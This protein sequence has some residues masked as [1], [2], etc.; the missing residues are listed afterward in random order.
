MSSRAD[1]TYEEVRRILELIDQSE[2]V[3][4]RVEFDGL[5]LHVRK[6]CLGE[7]NS[8]LIE[9]GKSLEIGAPNPV[10]APYHG[11]S[12][13]AEQESVEAAVNSAANSS[14]V[15]TV[16]ALPEGAVSI[17]APMLGRFYRA[18]S[19]S[20]PPF[21][22][23]GQKIVAGDTVGVIEVMKLFNDIKS[24]VSGTVVEIRVAN[25]EM[26]EEADILFV[27]ESD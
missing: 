10:P 1:L 14:K 3:E 25:S 17:N 21:V 9:P 2:D 24:E 20:N 27:V 13:A 16:A 23:V 11:A 5:K 19:P 12:P 6:G 15:E 7:G 26:V 4:L 18:S 22:E 8:S